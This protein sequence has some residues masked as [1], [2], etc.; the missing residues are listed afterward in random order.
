MREL[1][2]MHHIEAPMCIEANENIYHLAVMHKHRIL[3]AL[4]PRKDPTTP[5]TARLDLE[6]RAVHVDRMRA[7]A[8][9][10]EA[11]AFDN[12][13]WNTKVDPVHVVDFAVDPCHSIEGER[14]C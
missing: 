2:A 7:V 11:P 3:P 1:M 13:K 4:L 6:V 14:T 10:H 5:T 8:V 9:R 12:T